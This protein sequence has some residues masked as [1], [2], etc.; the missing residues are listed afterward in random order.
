LS[1]YVERS[2]AWRAP[3]TVVQFAGRLALTAA[4]V[5][6]IAGCAVFALVVALTGGGPLPWELLRVVAGVTVFTPTAIFALTWL[7]IKM[8]D[9]MWG[10]FGSPRSFARVM[11]LDLMIGLVAL[12]AVAGLTAAARGAWPSPVDSWPSWFAAAAVMSLA[13]LAS[14]RFEGPKGIR[15]TVWACL[16]VGGES[17]E[18]GGAA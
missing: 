10:A 13:S 1:Y 17:L 8:R 3:E 4:A 2:F 14:A 6:A 5:A 11:S 7:S 15:D 9:A 12:G 18:T 16:D